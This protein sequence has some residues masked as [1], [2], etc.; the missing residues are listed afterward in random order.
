MC[1][2]IRLTEKQFVEEFDQSAA[3][4]DTMQVF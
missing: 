1:S 4:G 3:T 2:F